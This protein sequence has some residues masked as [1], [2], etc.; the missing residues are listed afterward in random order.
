M[1]GLHETRSSASSTPF[2]RFARAREVITMNAPFIHPTAVVDAPVQIGQGTKIWHF[3]HLCAGATLGE[4]VVLGQNG[5]VGGTVVIG[6]GCRIQNNVSLYDGLV[7][8]NDVFVG[9]S[10]VFTNVVNPRAHINRHAE[11]KKTKIGYGATLGANATILPGIT[12][13]PYSF[14]A[15]GAVVTHDVPGH[16]LMAGVPARQVGWVSEEG[17]RLHDAEQQDTLVCVISGRYYRLTDDGLAPT[18]KT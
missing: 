2:H 10:V 3:C 4:N 8:E 18:A 14:I 6:N 11:F 1:Q 9:P 17:N 13:G 7:L 15:A 12:L 5:Y 16:A